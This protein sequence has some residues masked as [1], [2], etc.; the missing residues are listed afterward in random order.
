MTPGRRHATF[1][2]S[3]EARRKA[4]TAGEHAY[5]IGAIVA[6]LAFM[7]TLAWTSWRSP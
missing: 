4:M 6:A 5:L 2:A 1:S 3:E 7:T